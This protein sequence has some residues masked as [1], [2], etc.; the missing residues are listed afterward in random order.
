[1][2]EPFDITVSYEHP[3]AEQLI[4][5]L[6]A[7]AEATGKLPPN[8][9]TIPKRMYVAIAVAANDTASVKADDQVELTLDIDTN[10][11]VTLKPEGWPYETTRVPWRWLLT[12]PK[13]ARQKWTKR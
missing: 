13:A 10:V 12:K 3:V 9:L 4:N 2:P 11:K 6:R 7:I 1:M 5:G 8:P